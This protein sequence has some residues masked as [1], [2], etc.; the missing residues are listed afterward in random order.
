[1][2]LNVAPIPRRRLAAGLF[3]I[4][5]IALGVAAC[6][7]AESDRADRE[8]AGSQPA[9]GYRRYVQAHLKVVP[10][11]GCLRTVLRASGGPGVHR[12]YG[13]ILRLAVGLPRRIG[14]STPVTVKGEAL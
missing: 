7:D 6:G 10:S 12:I 13:V 9:E 1:M 3:A 4:G 5:T 14:I 8:Q 11:L 2:S